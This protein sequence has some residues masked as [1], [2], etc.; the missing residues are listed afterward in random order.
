MN[1][2]QLILP[3]PAVALNRS[4]RPALAAGLAI[5]GR[6]AL[7]GLTLALVAALVVILRYAVFEHFHGGD[8]A[9]RAVWE[10]VKGA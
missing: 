4:H 10:V 9:I 3:G 2:L 7:I 1:Q 8:H 5:A 6:V